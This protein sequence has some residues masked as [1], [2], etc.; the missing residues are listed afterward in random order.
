VQQKPGCRI[1]DVGIEA[2]SDGDKPDPVIFQSLDVVQ[3]VHEGA[4]KLPDQQ[5]LICPAMASAIR[6]FALDALASSVLEASTCCRIG[7]IFLTECK[8]VRCGQVR[9]GRTGGVPG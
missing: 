3:A 8:P 6:R 4:V 2:L 5:A 7:R 1:L 9:T